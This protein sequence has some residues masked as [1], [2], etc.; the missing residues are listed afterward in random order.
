MGW[1]DAA[2][3]LVVAAAL[4]YLLWKIWPPR[5][6]PDVKARDLVRK[7]KRDD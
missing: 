4:G 1:Q 3:F 6:R 7:K 2:V 5:R